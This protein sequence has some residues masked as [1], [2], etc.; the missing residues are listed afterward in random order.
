MIALRLW[1][2]LLRRQREQ[3]LTITLAVIAFGTATGALLT[4]LGGLGA[5]TARGGAHGFYV[6]LAQTATVILVIPVITLGGS[7]ARLSISR[8]DDRLAALRLAGATSGQVGMIAVADAAAQAL[9]G[10]VLGAVLYLIALPGVAMINFQGRAFTW[11]ELWVGPGVLALTI[12][13][14]ILL[15]TVSAVI[16]LARIAIN[17]LG[18][19][20]RTAPKSVSMIRIGV[21]VVALLLW[22]P[23][24]KTIGSGAQLIIPLIFLGIC[25][26]VLNLIGPFVLGLIGRFSAARANTVPKLLAARRLV[27]D[28]RAA[29]RPVAG[30]TLATFVA[31]VLSI[32]PALSASNSGASD[33][34]TAYLPVDLMTGSIVT[35]VIAALLAAVSA[36]VN[37]AARVYDLTQQYRMLHLIGTDIPVMKQA[38]MRETGLPLVASVAIAAFVSLVIVAPFGIP[39]ITQSPAGILTFVGGIVVSMAMVLTAVRISQ[40]LV[41]R[42][43]R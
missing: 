31:G 17:P 32:A 16:S 34:Q 1:W 26:G 39:L 18:V 38:R 36:G 7:A 6:I 43:I 29:W 2:L 33:P 8:R 37:Q 5:F 40:P 35:L 41:D 22:A 4:V 14:V 12:V 28:P 19:A 9:V 24:T 23:V 25:F 15:A 30:V 42:V 13:G 20:Q 11:S 3:Q 27:D 10:T 21:A